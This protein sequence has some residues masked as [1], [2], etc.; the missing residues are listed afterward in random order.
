M[1]D[2][3]IADLT[4]TGLISKQNKRAVYNLGVSGHFRSKK[5]TRKIEETLKNFEKF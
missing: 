5:H 4:N 1:D 3:S 2:L